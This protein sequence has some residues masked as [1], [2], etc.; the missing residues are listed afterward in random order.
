VLERVSHYG[1]WHGLQVTIK[2]MLAFTKCTLNCVREEFSMW[3]MA[4]F[5]V[6]SKINETLFTAGVL[7]VGNCM[8]NS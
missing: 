7:I 6:F 2:R 8:V 4:W 1:K 5:T 3:E